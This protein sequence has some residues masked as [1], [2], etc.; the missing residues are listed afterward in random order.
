MITVRRSN[1][2][3]RTRL[4][5]L[6]SRHTFSFGDYLDRAHMGF[7]ALRVVNDDRV[8]PGRGFPT[9]PH[10]DMEIVT[11]VLD[12]ALEHRDSLGNGS[13][14]RPGDAQR[15]SAGTGITHSEFNPSTTEPVRLLQI[16]ILPAVT[17]IAPGYEQRAFPDDARRGALRL[18]V[19]GDGRDGAVTIRQDVDVYA[20]L[21]APG[22][23][24]T[25]ALARG[26]HAW[27]QVAGGTVRVGD[28]S[29][30]DGDG[31]AV[32]DERTLTATATDS[33]ELLLFDLA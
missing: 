4:D 14:I 32:S 19:A 16:W 24:V 2:R 20:T 30:G 15:M 9:H 8:A 29:L 5:W 12:G 1:E 6:D 21:L 26:R 25:H 33:A 11:W 28:A 10:R 31:V 22:A 3:G 7:R 27:L 13:V 17:G 23:A 18:I